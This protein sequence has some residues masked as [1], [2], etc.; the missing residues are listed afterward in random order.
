VDDGAATLA[1][2]ATAAGSGSP[3]VMARAVVA[4]MTS[5]VESASATL[6]PGWAFEERAGVIESL[7]R[8]T[9]LIGV[10]RAGVLAAHKQDGRWAR[11]GDRS[12]EA[13]RGRTTRRGTG[14][15][16]AEVELA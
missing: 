3:V 1:G 16:R 6:A 15:A 12:F 9:A 13:F 10:Y 11:S 2:H 7:D 14:A 4:A 8:L 5:L